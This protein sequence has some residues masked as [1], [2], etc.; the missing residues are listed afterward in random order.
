VVAVK[1]S[2]INHYFCGTLQFKEHDL[3]V[4]AH[5]HWITVLDCRMLAGAIIFSQSDYHFMK[6]VSTKHG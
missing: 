5:K 4:G 2:A 3:K 6:T 1:K